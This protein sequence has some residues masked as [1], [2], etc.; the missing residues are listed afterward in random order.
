M[1]GR[2]VESHE[3][4]LYGLLQRARSVDEPT[5]VLDATCLAIVEEL[6]MDTGPLEVADD[7]RWLGRTKRTIVVECARRVDVD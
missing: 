7:E 3:T 4:S 1:E 6:A 2:A 5:A